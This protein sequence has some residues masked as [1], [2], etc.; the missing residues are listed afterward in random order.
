VVATEIVEN[1]HLAADFI[2]AHGDSE[3]TGFFQHGIHAALF[4]L[5]H[6]SNDL[7]PLFGIA[8]IGRLQELHDQVCRT[9]R[10]ACSYA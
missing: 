1:R 6:L 10:S 8:H 9:R 5:G 4:N 3:L 7:F 2:D